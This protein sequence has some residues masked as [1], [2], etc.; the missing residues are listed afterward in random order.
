[1]TDL[2][3]T[4]LDDD[5][6]GFGK[7]TRVRYSTSNTKDMMPAYWKRWTKKNAED[8]EEF[9]G[10]KCLVRT[11]GVASEDV[12]V[13]LENDRIVVDGK[14]EVEDY[15]YSQHVELPLSTEVIGN[16]KSV[17]YRSK[18]GMTYIYLKVRTPEYK[19]IDVKRIE[20]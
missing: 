18:D 6:F 14:T 4:F 20:A 5:F 12:N 15:T 8:K 1:M 17:E 7:P 2:I 9:L 16:V 11:V 13:T 19:K 10:Y 3:S